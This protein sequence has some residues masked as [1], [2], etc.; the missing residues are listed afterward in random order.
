MYHICTKFFISAEN[1]L[2]SWG[3]YLL[4]IQSKISQNSL[5]SSYYEKGNFPNAHST[6]V[7]PKLHKSDSAVYYSPLHLSGDIY[8]I[9]PFQLD[10]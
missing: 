7:M 9:V 1:S 10:I 6:I 5:P 3:S 8:F 2:G 4:Q